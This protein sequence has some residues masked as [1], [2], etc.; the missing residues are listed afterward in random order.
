LLDNSA[1]LQDRDNFIL[2]TLSFKTYKK[3]D[4]KILINN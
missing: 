4:S 2:N 1:I 3:I